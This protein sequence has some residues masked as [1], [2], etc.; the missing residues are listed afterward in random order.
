MLSVQ[1]SPCQQWQASSAGCGTG[2]I[3]KAGDRACARINNGGQLGIRKAVDRI[4]NGNYWPAIHADVSRFCWS[5]DRFQ[6]TIRKASVLKAPLQN[7]PYIDQPFERVA[8]D[9]IDPIHLPSEEG[10]RYILTLVDYATRYPEAIP[11]KMVSSK[12]VV[13]ALVNIYSRLGVH[14]EVLS[15]MALNLCRSACRRSHGC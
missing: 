9:L 6:R 15:D 10:H 14:G 3:T 13:E 4:L 12:T 1:T 5:C 11:L 7:I 8:V 2:A